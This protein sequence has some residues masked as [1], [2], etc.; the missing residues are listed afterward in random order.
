MLTSTIDLIQH[1]MSSMAS[2]KCCFFNENQRCVYK[3]RLKNGLAYS[4]VLTTFRT[5]SY[6]TSTLYYRI[7]IKIRLPTSWLQLRPQALW[8]R[9]PRPQGQDWVPSWPVPDSW[10]A[11]WRRNNV[12]A[13]Q[14]CTGKE[15]SPPPADTPALLRPTR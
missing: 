10:G 7:K 2:W 14:G 3:Y 15:G 6:K 1:I 12:E 11:R 4:T 13:L 5:I 9:R 8:H